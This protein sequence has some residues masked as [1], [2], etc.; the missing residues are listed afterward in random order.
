MREIEYRCVGLLVRRGDF[1]IGG[2]DRMFGYYGSGASD[3]SGGGI[4]SSSAPDISDEEIAY[5]LQLE[6]LAESSHHYS[7]PQFQASSSSQPASSSSGSRVVRKFGVRNSRQYPG[8]LSSD[9]DITLLRPSL[10]L[11]LPCSETQGDLTNLIVFSDYL[12]C[13]LLAVKLWLTGDKDVGELLL[14]RRAFLR[15]CR[16]SVG[17]TTYLHR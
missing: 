9:V 15:L 10:L 13:V 6:A 4:Q 16:S 1:G 12:L 7:V 8:T 11:R 3:S 14:R 2:E 17:C 5:Q